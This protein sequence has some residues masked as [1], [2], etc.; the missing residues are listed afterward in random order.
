[1]MDSRR[2]RIDVSI[3]PA[4]PHHHRPLVIL[5]S[6]CLINRING[7]P[8]EPAD[9]HRLL[10]RPRLA[11]SCWTRTLRLSIPLHSLLG[12]CATSPQPIEKPGPAL[13]FCYSAPHLARRCTCWHPRGS[14]WVRPW[15]CLAIPSMCQTSHPAKAIRWRTDS[16]EWDRSS[17]LPSRAIRS[18]T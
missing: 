10:R 2:H 8:R 5:P 16:S 12:P 1:M 6:P 14:F 15:T 18:T 9:T 13:W 4:K 17:G 3:R 11:L 7:L